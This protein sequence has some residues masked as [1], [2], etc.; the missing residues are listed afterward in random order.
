MSPY[1]SY[2]V[3]AGVHNFQPR[4]SV[5]RRVLQW[6]ILKN[7]GMRALVVRRP[8]RDLRLGS[9]EIDSTQSQ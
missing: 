7:A 6:C 1:R 5:D 3:R 2:R 4:C 9:P 8:A